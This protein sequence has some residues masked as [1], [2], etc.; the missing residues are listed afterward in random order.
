MES[1]DK[2]PNKRKFLCLIAGLWLGAVGIKWIERISYITT[3]IA[4]IVCKYIFQERQHMKQFWDFDPQYNDKQQ[5][6][7]SDDCVVTVIGLGSVKEYPNR[8]FQNVT[9]QGPNN[10]SVEGMSF[11]FAWYVHHVGERD[12]KRDSSA[13]RDATAAGHRRSMRCSTFYTRS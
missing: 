13:T 6:V 5:V 12:A 8:K 1:L 10:C 2:R 7:Y 11:S 3:I 9:I 4:L